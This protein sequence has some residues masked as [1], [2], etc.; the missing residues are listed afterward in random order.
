MTDISQIE[1]AD[2][3]NELIK[4]K[5]V[6]EYT[7]GEKTF[8][9]I[10]KREI[11]TRELHGYREIN[12]IARILVMGDDPRWRSWV[13]GKSEGTDENLKKKLSDDRFS[14]LELV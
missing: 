8:F 12:P 13:D 11:G 4:R 1:T 9:E 10:C 5:D 14:D 2:L 7:H 6:I 3:V